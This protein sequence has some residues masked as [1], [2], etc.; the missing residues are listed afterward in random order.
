MPMTSDDPKAIEQFRALIDTAVKMNSDLTHL[1][2]RDENNKPLIVGV[3]ARGEYAPRLA[4]FLESLDE[5]KPKRKR[6]KP[7]AI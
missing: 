5:P 2:A 3:I 6:K 4:A 7:D 1:T